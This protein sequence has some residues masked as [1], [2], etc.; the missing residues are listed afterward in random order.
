MGRLVLLFV[1]MWACLRVFF[2]RRGDGCMVMVVVSGGGEVH[3]R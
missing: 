2:E 3:H 1:V